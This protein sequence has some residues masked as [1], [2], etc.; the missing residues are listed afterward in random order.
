MISCKFINLLQ[1]LWVLHSIL[2]VP[3]LNWNPVCMPLPSANDILEHQ[4]TVWRLELETT[5]NLFMLVLQEFTVSKSAVSQAT[6]ALLFWPTWLKALRRIYNDVVILFKMIIG[7]VISFQI[8]SRLGNISW[9]CP[10]RLL[11]HEN[12][13]G[14]IHH[15]QHK[16]WI[17][18][19]LTININI[20]YTVAKD[21][22]LVSSFKQQF[23][24]STSKDL[25][26]TV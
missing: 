9:F 10:V 2:S 21:N 11:R 26:F 22:R 24:L 15:H 18:N 14:I 23:N 1:K 12:K 7:C 16:N 20:H 19:V 17:F 13:K 5:H 3:E 25:S 4:L 6:W 8:L